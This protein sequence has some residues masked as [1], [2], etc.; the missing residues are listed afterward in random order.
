LYSQVENQNKYLVLEIFFA[1]VGKIY[2]LISPCLYF[3]ENRSYYCL[4]ATLEQI[5][6][7][8]NSAN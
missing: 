4:Q 1:G 3:S 5:F 7:D 8:D 6:K 2:D